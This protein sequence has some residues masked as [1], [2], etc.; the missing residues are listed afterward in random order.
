MGYGFLAFAFGMGFSFSFIAF[1]AISAVLNPAAA[2]SNVILGY[3]GAGDFFVLISE[4]PLVS[5]PFMFKP[6]DVG[7][8]CP[9][10]PVANTVARQ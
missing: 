5:F 1:G 10:A 3:L 6:A 4:F 9:V 2:L 8:Y 7:G